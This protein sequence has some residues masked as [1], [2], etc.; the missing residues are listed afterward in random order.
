MLD[1]VLA[2]TTIGA[3]KTAVRKYPFPVFPRGGGILRVEAARVCRCD[4]R[5]SQADRPVWIMCHA[6][7]GCIYRIGTAAMHMRKQRGD[8]LTLRPCRGHSYESV[9][10]A[11]RSVDGQ[12]TPGAVQGRRLPWN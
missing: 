4:W 9:E 6:I 10:L 2:A 7:V 1:R 12:D 11:L 5:P 8:R 3:L